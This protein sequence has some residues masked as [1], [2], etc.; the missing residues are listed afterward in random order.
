MSFFTTKDYKM[1]AAPRGLNDVERALSLLPKDGDVDES[2]L[3]EAFLNSPYA[4]FILDW[5]G[6]ILVCNR[7]AER[8]FCPPDMAKPEAM[9][10]LHLSALTNMSAAE[11]K[12]L[13]RECAAKGSIAVPIQKSAQVQTRAMTLFQMSL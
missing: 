13:L 1:Y 7:R 6:R 9:R 12:K 11:L 5:S 8:I 10:G 3:A 4:S 2:V